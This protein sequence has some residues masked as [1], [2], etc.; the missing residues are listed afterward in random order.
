MAAADPNVPGPVAT[1]L[2]GIERD[3]GID[4]LPANAPSAADRLRISV[5]GPAAVAAPAPRLSG[6]AFAAW[7]DSLRAAGYSARLCDRQGRALEIDLATHRWEGTPPSVS[8]EWEAFVARQLALDPP[9]QP[10]R[11]PD[12]PPGVATEVDTI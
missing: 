9:P 4:F 11:V 12:D 2:F 6:P 3:G 8:P 10:P 7:L 1:E 5:R